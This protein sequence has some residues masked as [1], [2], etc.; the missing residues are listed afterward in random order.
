MFA[1]TTK[2]REL[3]GVVGKRIDIPMISEREL[4][5]SAE[6]S[7]GKTAAWACPCQ[8]CCRWR[9]RHG[10]R[11][12]WGSLTTQSVTGK[13]LLD[14]DSDVS[15]TDSPDL[16]IPRTGAG[17]DKDDAL[18]DVFSDD[19]LAVSYFCHSSGKNK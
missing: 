3:I 17:P 4:G 7:E 9:Q 10:R 15:D 5:T 11:S 14:Q 19:D 12:D 16:K 6:E 18:N 8:R 1:A 13:R 2:R